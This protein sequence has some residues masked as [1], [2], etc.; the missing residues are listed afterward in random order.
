MRGHA[1]GNLLATSAKHFIPSGEF[2]LAGQSFCQ[3]L[4]TS[5]FRQENR[6]SFTHQLVCWAFSWTGDKGDRLTSHAL[7][8]MLRVQ[9]SNA[10][11][12]RI[13]ASATRVDNLD[14]GV[15]DLIVVVADKLENQG[16]DTVGGG[17]IQTESS[18]LLLRLVGNG[19]GGRRP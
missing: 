7:T 1:Y 6:S 11:L 18:A 14:A 2:T 3:R 12:D 13:L 4:V 15:A 8:S 19:K 17:E 9:Q 5:G 16:P 10:L